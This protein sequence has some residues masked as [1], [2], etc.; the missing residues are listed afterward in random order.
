MRVEASLRGQIAPAIQIIGHASQPGVSSSMR[1]YRRVGTLVSTEKRRVS[2]NEA[3][4]K[5]VLSGGQGLL[6]GK[7]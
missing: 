7:P 3:Y 6:G 4:S 5:T 1:M 2:A